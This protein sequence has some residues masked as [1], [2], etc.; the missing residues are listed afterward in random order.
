MITTQPGLLPNRTDSNYR[1]LVLNCLP[2]S[3]THSLSPGSCKSSYYSCS[4][5]YAPD[6][7]RRGGGH[8]YVYTI[9]SVLHILLQIIQSLTTSFRGYTSSRL[10]DEFSRESQKRFTDNETLE[11]MRT[12]MRGQRTSDNM[13]FRLTIVVAYIPA[14]VK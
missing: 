14:V 11:E 4:R 2:M 9:S 10:T 8:V 13:S 5:H 1:F 12:T 7:G 6:G 3:S